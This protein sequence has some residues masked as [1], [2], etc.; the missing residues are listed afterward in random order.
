MCGNSTVGYRKDNMR[1]AGFVLRSAM[2][3][4]LLM[5]MMLARAPV[6]AGRERLEECP[7]RTF[8]YGQPWM[9]PVTAPGPV[10]DC[11]ACNGP[12]SLLPGPLDFQAGGTVPVIPFVVDSVPVA[13]F[14]L[15]VVCPSNAVVIID[16]KKTKSTDNVRSFQLQLMPRQD[17]RISVHVVQG[18]NLLRSETIN[19]F[20][21]QSATII[22]T[23][24]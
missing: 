13:T 7:K 17:P 18:Q 19:P 11:A 12:S 8:G 15:C 23:R 6:A 10:F 24:P 4:T 14:Q 21:S 22:V 5:G 1:Q 9:K 3:S 20:A 16:G 2:I